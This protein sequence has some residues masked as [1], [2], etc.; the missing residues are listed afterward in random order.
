MKKQ[1]VTLDCDVP[2]TVLPMFHYCY[3]DKHILSYGAAVF[4]GQSCP[5]LVMCDAQTVPNL[6]FHF[7]IYQTHARARTGSKASLRHFLRHLP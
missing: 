1:V 3:S 4:A 7:S 2:G 5:T 6:C